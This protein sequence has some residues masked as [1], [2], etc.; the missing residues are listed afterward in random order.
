MLFTA[1]CVS[2]I[3]MFCSI[4]FCQ[5]S[6]GDQAIEMALRDPE[7]FVLKPQR[8][9]GGEG[10]REREGGREGEGGRAV[11]REWNVQSMCIHFISKPGELMSVLNYCA[12]Y[13]TMCI[14]GVN[15]SHY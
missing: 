11:G 2:R 5:T 15:E 8:E 14:P 10:G 12:Y 4:Y 3:Q 7:R 13:T 6:E 9:G 1:V